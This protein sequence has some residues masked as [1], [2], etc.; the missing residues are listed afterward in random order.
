MSR[1]SARGRTLTRLLVILSVC[2]L[3][4]AACSDDSS[5][6]ADATTTSTVAAENAPTTPT[7]PPTTAPIPE[8]GEALDA[9]QLSIVQF[10]DE[11]FV[12]ILNTG[13]DAITLAGI[14]ICEFP[15]YED[16]ADVT[17]LETLAAG[18][19][20]RIP[21]KHL[22]GIDAADGEAALYDG[23]DFGSPDGMLSYVQWGAGDHRRASVAV[24][25][26]LWPSTDA[27]V[28]PNPEFNSIESGGFAAEVDGWS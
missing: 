10:G 28:T 9:L 25:A 8:T 15:D 1:R 24:D 26:G 13:A 2:S 6:G 23:S 7:E 21:A 17:D 19:T 5:D 3:I 22:A 20:L 16:L 11:G 12:E 4:A 27:F 14:N 18:E